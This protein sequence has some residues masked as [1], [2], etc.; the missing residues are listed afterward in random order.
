MTK[1]DRKWLLATAKVV[2]A[3]LKRLSA[4]TPL[5]VSRP[6]RTTTTNT[7]GWRV[8]IGSLGRGAP[9]LEIWLDRF[10]GYAERKLW[11][12]IWA[13]SRLSISTITRHAKKEL[14]PVRTITFRDTA[15]NSDKLALTKRLRRD[16]FNVPIQ[17]N[18]SDGCIFLGLYDNT[19][20]STERI[21][22][23]FVSRAVAFFSDVARAMPGSIPEDR[24]LEVYPQVENRQWVR[25]HLHRERSTLLASERK[26]R[27]GYQC[28]IC[29]FRFER[30][31]GAI[32]K[33]FAEA[34]HVVPLSQLAGA[35]C[36]DIKDLLTVCSNCH[37]M[38]HRMAGK[39]GDV[40]KLR[41]RLK[42]SRSTVRK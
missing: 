4:G 29:R 37:R 2:A 13:D 42:K 5:R 10:T 17:E 3:D 12:C 26:L 18:Y 31:Y 32:G 7:D 22:P 16:E 15:D 19:R 20:P 11:A 40:G 25:S 36:T 41:S 28:Q 1:H 33:G 34:H 38:L 35:V 14:W 9:K 6:K 23:H 39:R 21:N 8:R 30:R 24:D 27:D